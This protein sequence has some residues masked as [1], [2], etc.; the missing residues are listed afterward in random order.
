MLG[1]LHED[2]KP[3][4]V[5]VTA[6][7]SPVLA[8]VGSGSQGIFDGNVVTAVLRGGTPVY[9]SPHVR[10]LFFEAKSLPVTER[11]AFLE[12]NK[13][14]HGDDFFALGATIFD[15]FAECGWREG[16]SVAEILGTRSAVDLVGGANLRVAVPE[17]MLP[18]LQACF[19][20]ESTAAA[21]TVNAVVERLEGAFKYKPLPLRDGL[22]DRR[23]TSI[24]NNLDVALY[25]NGE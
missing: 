20:D 19:G 8:D 18:V 13:I 11:M 21:I 12:A 17:G 6:D 5:L 1:I 4:N 23:G 22:G 10:K 16:R 3:D 9:A 24:R 25:D 14:T 7:G 15:M 2:I